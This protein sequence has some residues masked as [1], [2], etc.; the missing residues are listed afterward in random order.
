MHLNIPK[1]EEILKVVKT[2]QENPDANAQLN[3]S[4]FTSY[5][6]LAD[7]TIIYEGAARFVEI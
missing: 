1:L 6:R 7:G 5:Y 4:S 2:H 3:T